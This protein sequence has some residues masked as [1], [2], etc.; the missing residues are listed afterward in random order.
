MRLEYLD[1]LKAAAITA[2]FLY[3]SGFMPFGYLGVDIFLVVNG[4]LVTNSLN[5]RFLAGET[6]DGSSFR[7]LDFRVDIKKYLEFEISKIV[8]LLPALL[9]ASGVCMAI[10]YIVMLPD[11]YENL[12]QSVIASNFF[13]NNI[14]S[15]ITTKNYWDVVNDYKPLSIHGIWAW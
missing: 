15:A 12:S 14:L 1:V 2:V 6:N 9:V 7:I 11:D 13:G 8:R 10:G 4:Y 5:K 3:H